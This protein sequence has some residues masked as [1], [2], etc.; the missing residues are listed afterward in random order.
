[1]TYLLI[2]F[3]VIYEGGVPHVAMTD[4]EMPSKEA[5]YAAVKELRKASR[6]NPLVVYANGTCSPIKRMRIK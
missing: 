1:M 6:S 2:A 4:R 3:V 5:C